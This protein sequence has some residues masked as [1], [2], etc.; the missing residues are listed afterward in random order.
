M[1][2]AA[3]AD[4][5]AAPLVRLARALGARYLHMGGAVDGL[6]LWQGRTLLVDWKRSQSAARTKTQKGLVAEGWPI[7]FVSSSEELLTLLGVRRG[8]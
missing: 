3:R 5:T 7:R 4:S 8:A 2:R 6:L 1:R